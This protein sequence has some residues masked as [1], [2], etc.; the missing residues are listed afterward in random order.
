MSSITISSDT[1]NNYQYSGSSATIR[2]Y[3]DQDFVTSDSEVIQQGSPRRNGTWY[4]TVA[5]TV[6]SN[7]LTIGSFAIDS[8]TD[9]NN[10]RAT[11]TAYLYDADGVRREVFLAGFRVPHTAGSP[12]TWAQIIAFNAARATPYT[13]YFSAD[14]M[15]AYIA[16]GLATK[17]D[18]LVSGT[19]IKT[20]N[21][22]SLLGS[23]NL[24]VQDPLVS[25]TNIKTVNGTSLL[26]SG[27]L[28]ATVESLVSA[29][30]ELDA[31]I[32]TANANP[33]LTY[34]AILSSNITVSSAKTVPAN[35]YFGARNGTKFVKSSSG[36]IAFQGVGL[37][38]PLSR[39]AIFSG[40]ASGDVTWTS[41][42]GHQWPFVISTELWDTGDS[43]AS[44]RI[45]RADAAL[46]GKATKILAFPRTFDATV[47]ITEYHT[48]EFQDGNHL[49]TL[50]TFGTTYHPA[51]LL[52]DNTVLTATPGARVHESPNNASNYFAFAHHMRY[53]TN[54]ASTNSNIVIENIH[55]IGSEDQ[56]DT[57]GGNAFIHLGNAHNSS[58]RFCTF[59]RVH[60]FGA[61]FGGY[62]TAGNYAYNSEIF[63]N[64]FIGMG[65]MIANFLNAKSCR[66]TENWFDQTISNNNSTY[67]LVDI[68][69]NSQDETIENIFIE[70]NVFDFTEEIYSQAEYVDV[71]GTVTSSGNATV[72]VTASGLSGS[73]VTVNVAVTNG[74]TAKQVAAA[75][76][77]ALQANS[78]INNFFFVYREEA[79]LKLA[80][81]TAEAAD[82]TF[83]I[84]LANG[85][86]AGL[87]AVPTSSDATKYAT[88]IAVQSAAIGMGKGVF[89]RRNAI[90]GRSLTE[91]VASGPVTIGIA[92]FGVQELVMEDNYIRGAVGASCLVENC[93]YGSIRNNKGI[94]VGDVSG[95]SSPMQLKS[96]AEF[97]V[98]GNFANTTYAPVSQD[99]G[100][101]ETEL[102]I[103]ATSSGS[104]VTT[105]ADGVASAHPCTFWKGL[106]IVYNGTDYT[107]SSVDHAN[108][109]FNTSVAVGTVGPDTAASATDVDTANN[110]ILATSHPFNNGCLLKYTAGTAVIPELTDGA[111]Y[112]VVNKG[113]NDYQLSLTLGGAAI[114]INGTGTGNQT[115][116]P[117][118]R[119]KFASN[120]FAE[121]KGAVTVEPSGTSRIYSTADSYKVTKDA[122]NDILSGVRNLTTTSN[123]AVGNVLGVSG[124]I[125][126]GA[127][128]G[129]VPIVDGA[130]DPFSIR[131]RSG[132][133]A[134]SPAGFVNLKAILEAKTS[135]YTVLTLDSGKVFTNEGAT[136][137]QDFTLP[138]A[139]SGLIYR[140]TVQDADG[141]RV[142]AAAGD[143]IRVAGSVSA[144]AGRIDSTTIGDSV[145]LEAINATEWIAIQ[146]VGTWT[147][148]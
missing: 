98:V 144:A 9:S 120:V 27:N 129:P 78:T 13:T 72:T 34:H 54:G 52:K 8:T 20:V 100:I 55:F 76:V 30:S 74:M 26:G 48:V 105:F 122:N 47:T 146:F 44:S 25:G 148:T 95:N 133:D 115:F 147:V 90:L 18:I 140:F 60:G 125:Y 69:P 121:N 37:T 88:A 97:D 71:A 116:T 39:V 28:Q 141:V 70:D 102:R 77:A 103:R 15:T 137:R 22:T 7:I 118:L 128:G 119:T 58:I 81:R 67:T 41:S 107:V 94:M 82:A 51:F 138:G 126:L 99:T 3:A 66:V 16:A 87:T 24:A 65:S 57:S 50:D 40:F 19:N 61:L 136:A 73:P 53:G 42:D 32:T 124:S 36:T 112:Y 91:D 134:T 89:I 123:V 127:I 46:L 110:K 68:E 33:S 104:T 101:Y 114:D 12:L 85:T 86:A 113:A 96:I 59:E 80:K 130:G 106:T 10:Q 64:K 35:V 79:R 11:Y 1:Q 45:A 63:H 75:A 132:A 92:A 5:C 21:S 17:Q 135:A 131:L 29:P 84:A 38:D 49:N 31:L 145:T 4:K 117:W 2:I 56:L 83:N 6:A 143:T 109:R 23:G 14:Q 142:I 111:F 108:N 43:S 62:G 93:R 139:V